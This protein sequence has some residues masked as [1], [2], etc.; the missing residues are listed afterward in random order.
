MNVI[1]W[2][3]INT[4]KEKL[5]NVEVNYTYGSET[6]KKRKE[7][8]FEKTH[9][10]DAWC[11]GK[12]HPQKKAKKIYY[13]K[14]RRNDRCLESFYDAKYINIRDNSALL[15]HVFVNADHIDKNEFIV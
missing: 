9:A 6:S 1:R 10:T 5:P 14:V 12:F 11:I 2:K 3:L 15:G 8:R 13:Q 4:L 7:L